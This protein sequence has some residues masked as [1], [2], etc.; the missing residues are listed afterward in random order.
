[1]SI[2]VIKVGGSQANGKGL[3]ALCQSLAALG[4]K[5]PLLIIPG[6][7]KFADT[8]RLY[9]EQFPLSDTTTHWMAI[10][11]MDQY[12]RL[13]ADLIPGSRLVTDMDTAT[14]LAHDGIPPVLL[15]GNYLLRKDPL[16]HSWEVTSDS[17]AAW[18]GQEVEMARL[19]LI[20]DV[21]GLY[22]REPGTEGAELM[23]RISLHALSTNKG[24]DRHLHKIME[25]SER[26]LWIVNGRHPQR[27]AQLIESGT[28]LGTRLK[29]N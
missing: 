23:E 4:R 16:P 7:G 28:T 5:H 8:V 1:M 13:L 18:I 25:K 3:K 22:T 21:D 10:L 2:T 12:G 27:V 20:K 14:S 29:K 26:E 19:I 9:A 17:I 11:G 24:V 15:P 6:G